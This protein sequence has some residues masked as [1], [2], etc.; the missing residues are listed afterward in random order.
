M[1]ARRNFRL[2]VDEN[3][4][5]PRLGPMLVTAVMARVTE[6]GARVVER[7]PRGGLAERLGDSKEMVAYGDIA[8]AEAWARAL[9]MRGAGRANAAFASVDDL[10]HAIAF[11][12]RTKLRAPCPDHV[13]AQCW[14]TNDE[15]FVAT[16]ELVATIG[17]D[18]DKLASKGVTIVAV[19]SSI[20][21]TKR[22]NDGLDR[23]K[24]RFTMDLH[25]MEELILSLRQFAGEE[26]EAICGKVGG[27]GKY[28]GAFGPLGGQMH[29]ILQE[30]RAKSMYRFPGLGD[31]A[32]VQDGDASDLLVS[33][34]SMVG[35]WMRE[36][37][38]ERIV[39]HYQ[40][41]VPELPGASGYHDPVTAK[42]VLATEL[43]RTEKRIPDDCFER[44]GKGG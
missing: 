18:L 12:D 14:N 7:K 10:V 29:A 32:F 28:S 42:F 21:C 2:G 26:V 22:L 17:K 4:L 35:K 30:S 8:L 24:S 5:G 16:D 44:R 41:L 15:K 31:I 39:R 36:V 3:G 23:G 6:D 20:V 25:A 37:L 43:V 40:G 34:A 38:M 9:A 33:L 1:N 27:F 11:E 19:R 13:A